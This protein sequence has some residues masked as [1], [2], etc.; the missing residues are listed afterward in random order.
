MKAHLFGLAV[1]SLG[2]NF[3]IGPA[4]AVP[5]GQCVASRDY[6][7]G[8]VSDGGLY[9]HGTPP[10]PGYQTWPYSFRRFYNT[11]NTTVNIFV[12]GDNGANT[13][14]A[15]GANNFVVITNEASPGAPLPRTQAF[16]CT[17]PERPTVPRG[18]AVPSFGSSVYECH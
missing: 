12:I 16:A 11:C 1:A 2:L 6:Q 10:G 8:T 4:A 15:V 5:A 9:V 7:A 17:Y 3:V 14:G 18:L 13:Y